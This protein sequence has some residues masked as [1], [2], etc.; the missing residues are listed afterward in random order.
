[1]KKLILIAIVLI[2]GCDGYTDDVSGRYQLPKGLQ[3]CQVYLM[4][5]SRGKDLYVVRC[6]N[7]TTAVSYRENKHNVSTTTISE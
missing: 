5:P 3:D 1:M 4:S 2:A 6:P 7:S